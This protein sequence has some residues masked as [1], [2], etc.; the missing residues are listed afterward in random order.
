VPYAETTVDVDGLGVRTKPSDDPWD[1]MQVTVDG[2]SPFTR[3][4]K[5]ALAV[6]AVAAR[7]ARAKV[8]MVDRGL[9]SSTGSN[10]QR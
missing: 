3:S 7:A 1:A 2:R 8:F 10:G 9:G 5:E 6:P 4:Q